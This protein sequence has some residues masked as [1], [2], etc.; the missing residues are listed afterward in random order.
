MGTQV[1]GSSDL[2]YAI[3]DIH[4]RADLLEEMLGR[5]ERH[6]AGQP[7]TIITLGDYVDR[8]PDSRGVI[9]LLR[10]MPNLI[11]LMGN[12]ERMLLD[13]ADCA[14]LYGD[15]VYNFLRNGGTQTLESFGV[16]YAGDIPEEYLHWLRFTTQKY[17]EDAL[18]AYVH[19]GIAW[20]LTNL[21]DQPI[22]VLTWIREGF[23]DYDEPFFKYVVHGHT[24]I[25]DRKPDLASVE[26]H[27]NRCNLDTGAYRTGV[28]T[29]GVFDTI[30]A[31]PTHLI[32]VT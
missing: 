20:C 8:G 12:H 25:H 28:L 10:G 7:H 18:R 26:I 5:I 3:G 6:A 24:P 29:C 31:E 15:D 22:D 13:A 11:P 2:T 1:T 27:H 19:A 21:A 30:Q 17:H 32:V 16:Q 4:G 9:D 23:L 14:D